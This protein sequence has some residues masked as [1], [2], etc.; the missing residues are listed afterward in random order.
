MTCPEWMDGYEAT[1]RRERGWMYGWN[2]VE[3]LRSHDRK[4]Q[5]LI[6]VGRDP[7]FPAIAA[8]F[9]LCI[10]CCGRSSSSS[11][12]FSVA[13]LR[14]ASPLIIIRRIITIEKE[15][16]T[17]AAFLNVGWWLHWRSSSA[18]LRQTGC[19]IMLIFGYFQQFPALLQ[20]FNYEELCCSKTTIS[21]WIYCI[22]FL[23]A[24]TDRRLGCDCVL[25]RKEE[26]NVGQAGFYK[27]E[28]FSK[29]SKFIMLQPRTFL[30]NGNA[31]SLITSNQPAEPS[32]EQREVIKHLGDVS[33]HTHP[34]GHTSQIVV[35]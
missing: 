31:R 8:V 20:L 13:S 6:F 29:E 9:L 21:K 24:C 2:M 22:P 32:M 33:T 18:R 34:Y 28:L 16:Q 11:F 26:G 27:Q 15:R 14:Q 23:A 7:F 1:R 5:N 19:I 3:P 17:T 12:P 25:D 35:Y 4:T 30:V 10:G